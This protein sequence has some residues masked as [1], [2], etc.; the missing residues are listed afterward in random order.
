ME[1]LISKT[2]VQLRVVRGVSAKLETDHVRIQQQLLEK[3]TGTL[4]VAVTKLESVVRFDAEGHRSGIR[5]VKYAFFKSSIQRTVNELKG[6]QTEYDPTWFLVVLV[7]DKLVD[8]V[9]K[10]PE[11]TDAS[12]TGPL[13]AVTRL[14]GLIS[15]V[16][17]EQIHINLKSNEFDLSM[18]SS[19]QYSTIKV[20][21]KNTR[22]S[23]TIYLVDTLN[24]SNYVDAAKARRDAENLARRLK[25][26][27][28]ET[29]GLLRC[30]GLVKSQNLHTKELTS[31][32]FVFKTPAPS[33]KSLRQELLHSSNVSLS[34]IIYMAQCLARSVYF[35]HV[36][37]LVH[38]NI[39]PE[40]IVTFPVVN[41]DADAD[42]DADADAN[43]APGSRHGSAYLLGFD[44][45]RDVDN[46]T[47]KAGDTALDRNL[48]RHPSRQGLDVQAAY[49]MQHD[50]YALG[51]CLL[52]IGLWTS[53]IS[54]TDNGSPQLTREL[55]FNAA[56]IDFQGPLEQ[57]RKLTQSLL[58]LARE[59]LPPRMGDK[60]TEVVMQCLTCLEPDNSAFGGEAMRDEDGVVV[61]ARFIETVL[62][63]LSEISV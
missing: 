17:Q 56:S 30:K 51:V 1:S 55:G 23:K 24:C 53:F 44:G 48:Y 60:Y 62:H 33:P 8:A 9:L 25:A 37:D 29:S 54:Y 27:D 2:S 10:Q 6:W 4:S 40:T 36:C 28:P 63:A 35:V 57:R 20:L 32:H 18:A 16:Q 14:R 49:I 26:I 22:T 21:T 39:R 12:I 42:T 52:E 38:K 43:T 7:H 5:A 41:A 13:Q 61:G 46:Q 45:F 58:M 31:M 19:L 47:L 3:L 50:I 15:G 59:K 34:K 11:T